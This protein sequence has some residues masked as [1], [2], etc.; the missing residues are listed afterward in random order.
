MYE[1]IDVLHWSDPVG[2]RHEL[3]E[4]DVLDIVRISRGFSGA[5]LKSLCTEAALSPMRERAMREGGS[6]YL[7]RVKV[8]EVPAIPRVHFDEAMR[9]VSASVSQDDLKAYLDWNA[10]YESFKKLE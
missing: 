8:E 1:L 2:N 6:R 10:I 5:D 4:A 3:S 7:N 9:S